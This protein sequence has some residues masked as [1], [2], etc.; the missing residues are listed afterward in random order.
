MQTSQIMLF[1]RI[2]ISYMKHEGHNCGGKREKKILSIWQGSL[3]KKLVAKCGLDIYCY[4]SKQST[5]NLKQSLFVF[6]LG[7]SLWSVLQVGQMV[8]QQITNTHEH[9]NLLKFTT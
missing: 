9:F 3:A 1:D 2:Y 7:N 6:C 4:I 8:L 5:Q